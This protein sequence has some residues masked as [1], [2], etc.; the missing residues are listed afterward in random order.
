MRLIHSSHLK[1]SR[2]NL[3]RRREGG[4]KLLEYGPKGAVK[5]INAYNKQ[6]KIAE[7]HAE[8]ERLRQAAKEKH[9]EFLR[10]PPRTFSAPRSSVF[11]IIPPASAASA[12]P[13]ASARLSTA[14]GISSGELSA[15]LQKLFPRGMVT[16]RNDISD[17]N[18]TGK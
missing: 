13:A 5:V 15:S 16:S 6:K 9:D 14:Q 10:Y 3:H 12:A 11:T 1:H 4:A 18:S 8:Y 17:S 2:R 7:E